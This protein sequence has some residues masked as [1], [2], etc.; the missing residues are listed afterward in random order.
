MVIEQIYLKNNL[1]NFNYIVY[2]EET[3]EAI[4]FD[5]MDVSQTLPICEEKE[6]T[7]KYL[8]NTHLH[9]DH[10]KDN[11]K[12]LKINGTEHKTFLPGDVFHLSEHEYIQ[13]VATPG[14]V[15]T[16][17]SFYLFEGKKMIGVISGDTVFN[18]GVGNCRDG[19]NPEVLFESIRDFYM[20]LEDDVKLYP[21]HDYFLTNLN[22]A[23]TVD[24]KNS[25]ID[26]YINKRSTQSLDEEFIITTI[27][28]EKKINPFFRVFDKELQNEYDL[29]AKSLFIKFRSL[30]DKW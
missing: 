4:F 24:Q 10:I 8:I 7:P 9:H 2:S 28:E 6:L 12:F 17:Y 3:K 16:H 1:R 27:G 13:C 22:F 19:G 11:E 20:T 15:K 30:R 14:H 26:E 18:S 23:K 5:P 25:F 21:S 29:D